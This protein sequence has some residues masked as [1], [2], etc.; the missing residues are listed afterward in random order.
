MQI[1]IKWRKL[2][3]ILL[4]EEPNKTGER[5]NPPADYPNLV[6]ERARQ[7]SWSRNNAQVPHQIAERPDTQGWC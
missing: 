1:L 5:V 2:N 4:R 6:T 3:Y 7:G